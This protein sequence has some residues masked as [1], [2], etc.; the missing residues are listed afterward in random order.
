MNFYI[1]F[2]DI[3]SSQFGRIKNIVIQAGNIF[4]E[5]G[6]MAPSDR[7]LAHLLES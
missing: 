1:N 7:K 5:I 3:F 6:R 2:S 4:E